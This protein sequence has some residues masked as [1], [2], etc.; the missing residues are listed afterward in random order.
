M[1]YEDEYK[2]CIHFDG[3]ECRNHNSH[4][5]GSYGEMCVDCEDVEV[6]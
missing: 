4:N 5:C 3:K 6:E 2:K 1:I